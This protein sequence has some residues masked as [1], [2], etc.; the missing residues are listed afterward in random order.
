M[1]AILLILSIS[2]A[3]VQAAEYR[4]VFEDPNIYS[5]CTDGPHG[6]IGVYDAF[7]MDDMV[8]DQDE[9]GIHIS[10]NI[11]TKWDFPRS[12]RLSARFH[13]MHYDRG[14][15]EPTIINHHSPDFCAVMF[16]ENLFWFKYWFGNI[17]NREEL[18]EQ[19]ITTKGTVWVFK[20]FLMSM[21][22]QNILIPNI[23]GRYKV[24]YTF[25]AF[26]ENN[27]R[28]TPSLCFEIRGDAEK[29]K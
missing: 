16:D 21:R 24:V 17:V 6:S 25:E 11:T 23:R 26:D 22:I 1:L 15:W 18:Q 28:R 10:G 29:I 8:F 12:D 27:K 2:G 3:S 7:N 14:T 20:P 13:I 5:S 19:C 9:E 4:L